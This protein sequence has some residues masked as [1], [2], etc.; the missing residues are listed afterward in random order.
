MPA[1]AGARYYVGEIHLSQR[2]DAAKTARFVRAASV[3]L[4]RAYRL[5]GLILSDA[6]EAQDAT[7]DALERAWRAQRSLRDPAEFQPWFDRILLNVCRDRLRRRRRLTFVPLEG[8]EARATPR[9]AFDAV[10]DRDLV[11]RAMRDLDADGRISSSCITD[12]T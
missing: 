11:V 2:D 10:D 1:F 5:A 6:H 3:E 7:Q 12:P 8:A 4:D 9:D